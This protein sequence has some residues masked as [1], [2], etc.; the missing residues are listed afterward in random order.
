[1]TL[2]S[3][4]MLL[5]WTGALLALLCLLSSGQILHQHAG[6]VHPLP[7]HELRRVLPHAVPHRLGARQGKCED[8]ILHPA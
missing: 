7:H 1:M 8:W 6:H 3:S 4:D 2:S 5:L